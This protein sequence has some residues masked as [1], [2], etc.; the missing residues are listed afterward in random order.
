[1]ADFGKKL[2]TLETDLAYVEAEWLIVSEEIE[3][4]EKETKLEKT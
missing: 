4:I 1:M 3:A 2:K